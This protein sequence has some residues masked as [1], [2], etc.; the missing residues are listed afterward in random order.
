MNKATYFPITILMSLLMCGCADELES[1]KGYPALETGTRTLVFRVDRVMQ[2]DEDVKPYFSFFDEVE[3]TLGYED[4]QPAT[5]T[6]TESGAPFRVAGRKY[7]DV[8]WEMYT[9]KSPYEIREKATGEVICYI[10]RDRLVTF[11]FR[12]GAPSNKYEYRLLPVEENNENQ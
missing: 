2:N 11:P 4:G 7:V 5:L 6:F 1:G 9:A 3:L 8:P 10:T 12:L